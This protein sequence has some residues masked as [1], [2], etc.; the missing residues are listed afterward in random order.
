M[1]FKWPSITK[2]PKQER[3]FIKQ[4]KTT[5]I[6]NK[7]NIKWHKKKNID[8]WQQYKKI[9]NPQASHFTH[10]VELQTLNE[11]QKKNNRKNN[12]SWTTNFERTP[13]KKQ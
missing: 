9:N 6:Q 8:T 5:I 2:H 7:T 4:N 11:H 3:T 10:K 1:N 12:E 13:K